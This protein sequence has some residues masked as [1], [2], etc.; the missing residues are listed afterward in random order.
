MRF[1]LELPYELYQSMVNYIY[2]FFVCAGL[3]V[4]V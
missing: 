3:N 4:H 2:I 1:S